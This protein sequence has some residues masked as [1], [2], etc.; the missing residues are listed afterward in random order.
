MKEVTTD[1]LTHNLLCHFQLKISLTYMYVAM[2]IATKLPQIVIKACFAEPH[3]LLRNKTRPF[4]FYCGVVIS[5]HQIL[6][7]NSV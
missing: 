7:H 1:P 3:C 6:E 2:A 4:S 5:G